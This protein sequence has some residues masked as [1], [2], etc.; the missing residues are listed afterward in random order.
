VTDL[1]GIARCLELARKAE[2]RTAPNPIVGGVV[3]DR[4]GKI[5]GEGFHRGPGTP[6]GE[7]EA[8]AKAGAKAKGGTLYVNLEPCDHRDG[9]RIPCSQ[10][11]IESGVARVV[12]GA[13]DPIPGHAGGAKRIARAKIR[14]TKGVLREA[15]E[16]ANAAFFTWATQGRPRFILKAAITLDGKIAT[17]GGESQWITSEAARAHG[18]RLRGKVDAILVGVG[19]V[20]ADDPKLTARTRGAKDPVRIVLDGSLR[21]PASAAMLAEPGR[22]IIVTREKAR[23]LRGAELWRM[24]PIELVALAKRLGEAKMTSVLVEGGAETHARF[25]AAGLA[26]ELRVYVAPI[27][28]GGAARSWVGGAGVATLAEAYRFEYAG[29]PEMIGGDLVVRLRRTR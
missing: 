10:R 6:H 7:A 26:D 29:A 14:V 9:G 27:A 20:L 13:M 1:E 2:G 25:L 16:D 8:L 4:R 23:E 3:V 5:V 19:T 24:D 18:R 22:T 12:I 15:C 17:A 28:V 11:V 21:T